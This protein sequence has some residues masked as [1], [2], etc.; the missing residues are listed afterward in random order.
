VRVLRGI[1]VTTGLVLLWAAA[2]IAVVLAEA[3]W[4]G[5]RAVPRGDAAA[6]EEHLVRK[7]A[8]AAE[9]GRLGCAAVVLVRGGEIAAE[10]G[11]GV[12]NA[13]T[14]SPVACDRTLFQVASVSKAV[15]A[16][17]VMKLV[18]EGKVGL[19][20]PV[21]RYLTRWRFPGSDA[22]RDRVTVRH[23][24]SHTAG[25]DDGLGYGGFL[26]GEAV[27][28]LEDSLTSTADS[29][30]SEPRG[31]AVTREPGQHMAYSGGGY[32]VLQ[33]LVEEVTGRPFADYM[34]DAVLRPL[35]MT[36][37]GFDWEAIAA[38]DLATS[39]DG[40]LRPQPR[41]RYAAQAAVSLYAT[42]RDL[43]RFARAF[44]RENPVLRRET[45]E[46]MTI[47]QQG[48]SGTWGLGHTLFVENGAGGHVVGHDGGTLPAWGAM[49]RV[50]PATGNGMAL[51]VSGGRGAVNRLVHDWVYW[52]T[53]VV[54]PAA[55]LQ[56]MQDRTA[57]AAAAILL[58][59][60]A[61]VLRRLFAKRAGGARR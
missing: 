15:T 56:V 14:R 6:I 59:A 7:L 26:P 55:R 18:E 45:I 24:L 31:V 1:L 16:W 50:N 33:L 52:E 4:I 23:L 2:V 43:A 32:T 49:V 5:P 29:T 60:V 22:R 30:V 61:I 10:H 41:R 42:P 37:S 54:T 20:D 9:D 40:D 28:S 3:Y 27:Q 17:G 46:R 39:Y 13:E 19:D 38:E 53:G 58:G 47:P 51:T 35:G 57:A 25:L 21:L 34:N 8:D 11:F 48:T 12:A 44:T 36:E